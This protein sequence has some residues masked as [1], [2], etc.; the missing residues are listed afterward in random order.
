MLNQLIDF[1]ITS[2]YLVSTKSAVS[3]NNPTSVPTALLLPQPFKLAGNTDAQPWTG[4]ISSTSLAAN[5]I[6]GNISGVDAGDLVRYAIVVENQGSGLYGAFDILIKDTLP[7]GFI[8]P[9]GGVNLHVT[10]GDGT[11]VA[12][13]YQGGG[14]ATPDDDLFNNGIQLDDTGSIG[15]CEHYDAGN[16]RN[17]AIITYDLQVDPSVQ[18]GQVIVNTSSV[19]SYAGQE[20]GVDYTGT[21]SLDDT[22]S[23]T[24]VSPL[25]QKSLTSTSEVSATNLNAQAVIGEYATYTLTLTVPE[26]VSSG[27]NLV[28]TMDEGLSFVDVQSITYSS[29]A[30]TSSNTIDL[31]DPANPTNVT[32]ANAPQAA[33]PI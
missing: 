10:R 31:T 1:K 8:L 23:A 18:P 5:P 14:G 16:G 27:S 17:I 33:R 32:I 30:V 11:S 22:A 9:P 3:S 28:D 26:G 19:V 25:L 24:I 20:G 13:T 7:A 12:F 29:A 2:P 4:I 6:N 21:G 15:S